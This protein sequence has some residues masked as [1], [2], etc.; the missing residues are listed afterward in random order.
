MLHLEDFF[1][2]QECH[3]LSI[4]ADNNPAVKKLINIIEENADVASL[5]KMK[6][7][8]LTVKLCSDIDCII[9]ESEEGPTIIKET[10]KTFP[11]LMLLIDKAPKLLQ[12]IQT[13]SGI[14]VKDSPSSGPIK[15]TM[16][17]N[18]GV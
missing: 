10:S 18:T 9:T 5:F 7:Q 6:L 15:R 8:Q 14:D 16:P 11:H 12:S 4:V 17:K 13:V 1:T 3:D 2:E